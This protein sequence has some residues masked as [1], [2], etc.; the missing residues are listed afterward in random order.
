MVWMPFK[1]SKNQ[2]KFHEMFR[3]FFFYNLPCQQADPLFSKAGKGGETYKVSENFKLSPNVN[4]PLCHSLFLMVGTYFQM[5]MWKYVIFL[6]KKSKT[7]N[8]SLN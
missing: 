6:W 5:R 8:I 2:N 7:Y 3:I 1:S 4:F